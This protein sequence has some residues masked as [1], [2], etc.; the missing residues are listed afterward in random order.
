[1]PYYA[2]KKY[3]VLFST[4]LDKISSRYIRKEPVNPVTE[5]NRTS[6]YLVIVKMQTYTHSRIPQFKTYLRRPSYEGMFLIEN[7]HLLNVAN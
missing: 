5:F 6:I 1:M 2:R 3:L 7:R 4:I